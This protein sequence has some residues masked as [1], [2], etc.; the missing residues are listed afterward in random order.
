MSLFL[1]EVMQV[2]DHGGYVE[3]EHKTCRAIAHTNTGYRVSRVDG[4][5]YQAITRMTTLRRQYA[6]AVETGD[7]F[8][9]FYKANP[10]P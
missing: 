4:R 8:I 10:Q 7:L 9:R 3:F 6:G 2:L 1:K 5:T